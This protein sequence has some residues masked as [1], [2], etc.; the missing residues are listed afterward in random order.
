M[1]VGLYELSRLFNKHIDDLVKAKQDVLT[2][3]SAPD[4]ATY[5]NECGLINGLLQAKIELRELIAK[6]TKEEDDDESEN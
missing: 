4:F 3:G 1:S 2:Q 6:V 5:K